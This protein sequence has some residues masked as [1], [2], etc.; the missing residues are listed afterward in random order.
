LASFD[1]FDDQL[2]TGQL[3]AHVPVHQ[4]LELDGE[5][6]LTDHVVLGD[7][8][9][10]A[11]DQP[12]QR[13]CG[14]MRGLRILQ[15]LQRDPVE[16]GDVELAQARLRVDVGDVGGVDHLSGELGQI[17][18]HL[19]GVGQA[20]GLPVGGLLLDD[21][22]PHVAEVLDVAVMSQGELHA[23][24]LAVFLPRAC[25]PASPYRFVIIDDPVQSMD[26]TKIDGLAEVL[27]EVALTRQAIVFTHD[28]RLPEAIRRLD[29]EADI[30]EVNRREGSIVEI[31]KLCD[32]ADRYLDD[33]RA[34]VTADIPDEAKH[35]MIAGFCRSAIESVSMDRYRAAQHRRGTPY[36]Q[37]QE[38]LGRAHTVKDRLGLGLFGHVVPHR[39][40]F[41]RLDRDYGTQAGPTVQA[42]AKAV[43]GHRSMSVTLM[44]SNT[45]TLV[46]RLR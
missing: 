32:P 13:R 20:L 11:L 46:G 16:F 2:R 22:D 39:D 18:F 21:P 38:A 17:A 8:T 3:L 12:A 19:G 28:D 31:R 29:I 34:L 4:V 40:L 36:Q 7:L 26:P 27:R 44:V 30:R 41:A 42:V 33:A 37:I 9:H 23:L 25:A 43:H 15:A 14:Q 6:F 5:A 35:L 10:L 45:A 24:G 1:Q